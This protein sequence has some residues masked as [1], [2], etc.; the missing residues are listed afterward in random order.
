[1]AALMF[2]M[3]WRMGS[4]GFSARGNTPWSRIT[5][6]GAAFLVILDDIADGFGDLG[7]R[8]RAEVVR[9]D[10]QGDEPGVQTLDLAVVQPPEDLFGAVAADAEVGGVAFV[11]ILG[12][13]RLAAASASCR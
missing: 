3:R 2:L 9:A 4:V 1:M 8:V 5:V 11:V 7:V 12:P 6:F 13:H 10:H